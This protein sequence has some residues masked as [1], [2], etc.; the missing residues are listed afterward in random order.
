MFFEFFYYPHPLTYCV[1]LPPGRWHATGSW[2]VLLP[3]LALWF[4]DRMVRVFRSSQP[5][6]L[7]HREVLQMGDAGDVLHLKCAAENMVFAPGHYAFVNVPEISLMQWH[8]FTIAANRVGQLEFFIK[9]APNPESFTA[10]LLERARANLPISVCIDGPY[11][12]PVEM[13]EHSHIF[14]V[15]G[16]VGITPCRAVLLSLLAHRED[17]PSLR[18][19][20]L[21]WVAKDPTTFGILDQVALPPEDERFSILLYNTGKRECTPDSLPMGA[22]LQSGRPDMAVL[23]ELKTEELDSALVFGCG[24]AALLERCRGLANERGWDYHAETFEL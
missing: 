12:L 24:P 2:E 18:R 1:L 13:T 11:G 14:L 8:P 4:A 5:H 22:V 20:V 6:E 23:N 3:P 10:Q 19:V 15:A 21:I 7:V 9:A 16:G 17:L